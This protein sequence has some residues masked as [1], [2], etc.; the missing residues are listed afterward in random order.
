M[1]IVRCVLRSSPAL[2]FSLHV[3]RHTY[4]PIHHVEKSPQID[5]GINV[6]SYKDKAVVGDLSYAQLEPSHEISKHP[7]HRSLDG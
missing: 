7:S 6:Q 2:P 4:P 5:V 1:T 3:V